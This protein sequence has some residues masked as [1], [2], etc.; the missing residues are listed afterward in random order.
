MA[1]E[2]IRALAGSLEFGL[3]QSRQEHSGQDRNEA[4]TT[5]N[6]INVKANKGRERQNRFSAAILSPEL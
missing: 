2:E 3:A 1:P 4:I 6:S 5:N